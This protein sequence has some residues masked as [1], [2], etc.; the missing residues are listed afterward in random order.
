VIPHP[1]GSRSRQEV[2]EM[3]KQC[4]SEIAA[5]AARTNPGEQCLS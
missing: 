4:A 2:R 1:F 3:A 5:F